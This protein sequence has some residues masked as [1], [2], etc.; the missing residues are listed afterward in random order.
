MERMSKL[1]RTKRDLV[2][3]HDVSPSQHEPITMFSIES[4]LWIASQLPH[5]SFHDHNVDRLLDVI[6]W[7]SLIHFIER[8]TRVASSSCFRHL[9]TPVELELVNEMSI[10]KHLRRIG[11]LNDVIE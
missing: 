8:A 3:L 1:R 5:G 2:K 10:V 6:G 4:N 7:D 11:R 9:V